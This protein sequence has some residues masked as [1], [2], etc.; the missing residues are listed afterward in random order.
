MGFPNVWKTLWALIT[1][2]PGLAVAVWLDEDVTK[3]SV[4]LVEAIV[5]AAL[6]QASS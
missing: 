2:P 4:E 6:L 5:P 1:G 3:V